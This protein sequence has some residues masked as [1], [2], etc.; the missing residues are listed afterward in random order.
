VTNPKNTST[1]QNLVTG[2]TWIRLTATLASND[3]KIDLMRYAPPT[4]LIKLRSPNT[5]NSRCAVSISSP[6]TPIKTMKVVPAMRGK[7]PAKEKTVVRALIS[8]P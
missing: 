1:E 8:P 2:L 4:F 7:I 6:Y 5:E 3:I